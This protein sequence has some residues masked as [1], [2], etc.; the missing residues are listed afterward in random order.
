LIFRYAQ[1]PASRDSRST[2]STIEFTTGTG[3]ERRCQGSYEASAEDSR[4]RCVGEQGVKSG[5]PIHVGNLTVRAHTC[6]HRPVA[7]VNRDRSGNSRGFKIDQSPMRVHLGIKGEFVR[8][9]LVCVTPPRD[10]SNR[11]PNS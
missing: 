10:C 6:P 8:R 3:V 1:V 4:H 7:L 11:N 2:A 5:R 9:F